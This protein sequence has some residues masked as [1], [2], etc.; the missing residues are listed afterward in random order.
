MS[1]RDVRFRVQAIILARSVIDIRHRLPAYADRRLIVLLFVSRKVVPSSKDVGHIMPATT[2]RIVGTTTSGPVNSMQR[3]ATVAA[4][5]SVK[6]FTFTSNRRMCMY[7]AQ[8]K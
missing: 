2:H 1:V 8:A 6:L 5:S 3:N 7:T 4:I